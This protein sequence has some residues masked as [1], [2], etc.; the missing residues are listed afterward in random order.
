[1]YVLKRAVF[2]LSIFWAAITLNFLLPRMMPGNAATAVMARAQGQMSPQALK[3]LEIA[4][5]VSSNQ[6]LWHQ[7]LA[8]LWNTLR[9]HFGIS[10]TYFPEPVSQVI[11]STLPW[12]LFLIGSATI[13]SFVIGTGLGVLSAWR[14]GRKVADAI[15]VAFT[16]IASMPYFW[17]ALAL[18]YVLGFVLGWFPIAHS[19]SDE[20]SPGFNLQT[21]G[22]VL[23]HAAL[24]IASLV[25]T[26]LGGWMLGMRNN[27][28]SV[29][30]E[31]YI[32]LA[33]MKG[34]P[35]REVVTNY[36]TR[37]AM[38]PQI[39]SFAMSLGF[40]VGGAVVTEI[41]FSYPGIGY[42]LYQAVTNSDYPLMQAI[43]L[44]IVTA[45]LIANFLIDILYS[46]LDPRVSN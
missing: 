4:F 7:Y 14:R 8:Y 31:D 19:F 41:V 27:L 5:G 42:A 45:V 6:P 26:S 25:V 11:A 24:P 33:Q 32:T 46:R 2:Y 13:I 36:A 22:S 17:V 29:L 16:L 44:I 38:L 43:F 37:N 20:Q 40:V 12:T 1:M 28:I 18:L 39:T 21:I 3:A 23:Y 9:G 34:L 35:E 30:S 15:P 10:F